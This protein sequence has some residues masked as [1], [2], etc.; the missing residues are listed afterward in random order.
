MEQLAS[1]TI[2]TLNRQQVS[3]DLN[4]YLTV[5][6]HLIMSRLGVNIQKNCLENC[7]GMII[8]VIKSNEENINNFIAGLEKIKGL[9]IKTCIF[10]NE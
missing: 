6:G 8:L 3:R 4:D 9:K 5:N 2:L 1:I 10:D 7:P